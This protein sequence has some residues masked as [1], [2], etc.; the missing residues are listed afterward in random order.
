MDGQR[1]MPWIQPATLSQSEHESHPAMHVYNGWGRD[2][3]TRKRQARLDVVR[4]SDGGGSTCMRAQ[5]RSAT[6]SK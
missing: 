3:A 2:I 5:N 1:R 6:T 4:K